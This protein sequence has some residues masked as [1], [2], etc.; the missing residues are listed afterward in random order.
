MFLRGERGLLISHSSIPG[1]KLVDPEIILSQPVGRGNVR[2]IGNQPHWGCPIS[3]ANT[4]KPTSVAQVSL[5]TCPQFAIVYVLVTTM[6]LQSS[7]AWSSKEISNILSGRCSRNNVQLNR[8][9][10]A[11]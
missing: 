3:R 10:F 1:A 5:F 8:R 11:N 9:F 2:A 7:D 4:S 6:L